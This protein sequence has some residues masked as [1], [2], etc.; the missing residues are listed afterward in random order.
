MT[1]LEALNGYKLNLRPEASVNRQDRTTQTE[2]EAEEREG[3]LERTENGSANV[4][5]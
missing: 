2:D 3:D 4:M 5:K 1:L